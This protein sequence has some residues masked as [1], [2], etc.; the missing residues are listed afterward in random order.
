MHTHIYKK[1]F[2]HYIYI[3]IYIYIYRY[4]YIYI[5]NSCAYP[6]FYVL[7]EHS[8]HPLWVLRS[9]SIVVKGPGRRINFI[10]GNLRGGGMGFSS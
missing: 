7:K 10:F 9:Y 5:L 8:T 4:I 2:S 6:I 3:Y 1:K